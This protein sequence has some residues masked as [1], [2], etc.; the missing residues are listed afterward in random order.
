MKTL[1]AILFSIAAML[2]APAFAQQSTQVPTKP[3][4]YYKSSAGYTLLERV[5]T[6]G[7]KTTGKGKAA[8]SYG[9]AKVNGLFIYNNPTA[10]LQ[11][12]DQK[13]NFLIITQGEISI[14]DI[15]LVKMEQKKDHRESEYC[16]AGAWT[17]VRLENKSGVALNVTRTPDGNITIV[18][19]Q[20]LPV[21]EYLLVT[22]P[23][24]GAMGYDFGVK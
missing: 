14:Q 9:I 16:K 8:F 4:T 19:V 6:S 13:P 2:A 12:P 3:G 20:D 17:G 7:F 10:V 23:G 11:L 22:M 18:P 1:I 24:G 21:G 15:A 5:T